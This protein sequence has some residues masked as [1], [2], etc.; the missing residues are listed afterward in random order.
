[1]HDARISVFFLPILSERVP[2][3][4]APNRYPKNAAENT[5]PKDSVPTFHSF[6]MY[7][8]GYCD[9]RIVVP[10]HEHNQAAQK[11]HAERNSVQPGIVN[12]FADIDR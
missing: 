4:I 7:R 9:D 2:K 6:M 11:D 10:I 12:N 8:G 3:I 1:M 5:R